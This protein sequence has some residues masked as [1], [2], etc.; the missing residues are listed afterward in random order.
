MY[1]FQQGH[2]PFNLNK[3]NKLK[4]NETWDGLVF[5][6]FQPYREPHPLPLFTPKAQSYPDVSR[7]P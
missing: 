6:L 7:C 4:P 3:L 5:Q 1:D 2:L